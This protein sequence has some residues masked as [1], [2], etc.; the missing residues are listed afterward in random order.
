[1]F[2]KKEL[3]KIGGE[4]RE[5]EKRSTCHSLDHMLNAFKVVPFILSFHVIIKDYLFSHLFTYIHLYIKHF[6]KNG[7]NK[8]SD[9]TTVE[10]T[11]CL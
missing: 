1:M 8:F 10:L 3:N 11:K 9:K 5:E 4:G 6:Y 7:P 2:C